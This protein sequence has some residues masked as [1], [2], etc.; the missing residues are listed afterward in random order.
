[1]SFVLFGHSYVK[2][3]QKKRGFQ[4]KIELQRQVIPVRCIGEG[5]LTLHR[6]Q[7]RPRKFF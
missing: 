4:L 6:I 5:G 2:R 1:M 3:L 7:A